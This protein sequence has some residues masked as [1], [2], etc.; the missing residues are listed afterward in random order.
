MKK[1]HAGFLLALL[2]I[3]SLSQ[4]QTLAAGNDSTQTSNVPAGAK[5]AALGGAFSA[6]D[7]DTSSVYWNPAG[8]VWLP[9][10]QIETAY[11]Q[12]FQDSFFQD[13]S[14]VYPLEWGAVGGRISYVNLGSI[15]GRDANGTPTNLTLSPEN[16]GGTFATAVKLGN[17]S[18]GASLKSY[19]EVLTNTYGYGTL[20]MDI[21]GL[22]R[23][24]SLGLAA[25]TRNI[26][27]IS[28]Y[29]ALT[30]YYSGASLAVG[31]KQFSFHLGTDITSS[32]GGV[33]LHH[34]VELGYQ[35]TVFVRMGL[36]WYPQPLPNQ[37]EG[38]LSG[39]VGLNLGDFKMD[40][41]IADYGDLG[42][43]NRVSL[44]YQFT[45][46]QPQSADDDADARG[47]ESTPRHVTVKQ[48]PA[49]ATTRTIVAARSTSSNTDM[50][51][52][53]M[54]LSLKEAYEIGIAAY[55]AQNYER[56]ATY[57][58]KT[59][60]L[61][62][63]EGDKVYQAEANSM[64]GIIYQYY[65]ETPDST[66]LARH[67][68]HAALEIDPANSTALKHLPQLESDNSDAPSR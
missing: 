64:L 39:G 49:T 48:P 44:G 65:L 55:K 24:G 33:V 8:M 41:S 35:Q 20:N 5:A 51:I 52:P 26:G 2:F 37:E 59:I 46:P 43:T 28:P 58:K 10:I 32:D 61:R 22:L 7:D 30:E 3:P 63:T 66:T 9:K 38:G 47:T 17:F 34:G 45:I 67:Y 23:L 68:Y 62:P 40:Y 53:E 19:V 16:W 25:G 36:Q 6:W 15:T 12:W 21:G 56:A 54:N 18:L 27:L 42:L 4:A 11:N 1:I 14:G 50:N 57:L 29:N 13:L 60:S 31:S